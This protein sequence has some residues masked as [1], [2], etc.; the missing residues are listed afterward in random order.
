V[1][2][3]KTSGDGVRVA[4]PLFPVEGQ[5]SIPMSPLQFRI[6]MVGIVEAEKLN[7][8][9]HSRL[10][11]YKSGFCLKAK[12]CFAASYRN[13]YFAVAIW[14]NPS[15]RM[16]NHV[17]NLEL[18]RFAISDDAPKNTASRMLKIMCSI[19][20]KELPEIKT[21]I[22]Y[23]DV[24]VHRGTIYRAAG[25]RPVHFHKG[26]SWYRPNSKNQKT[27][28]PRT[29]PDLNKAVGAKIRWERQIRRPF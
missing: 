2:K 15:A 19:I 4:Q 21:L 16:L 7:K 29:R 6:D 24:E 10:P 20:K 23:Q 28:T 26:G 12:L 1:I 11:I 8:L 5:G 3:T 25:W 22:S 17:T 27:N 18:K 14:D 9:W 13:V